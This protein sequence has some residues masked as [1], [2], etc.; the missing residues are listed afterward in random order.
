MSFAPT[1]EQAAI[2]AAAQTGQNLVIQAGAG[3][4]KTSTL[5][6]IAETLSDKR[7]LYIAFNKAI[8]NEA[9]GSMGSNVKASTAHS[10]AFQSVGKH[11]A[12]RLNAKRMWPREVARLLGARPITIK[13]ASDEVRMFSD[14][15]VARMAMEMVAQFCRTADGQ[16]TGFHFPLTEGIDGATVSG[17]PIRGDNHAILAKHVLPYAQTMWADLQR[18]QGQFPFSHDH[19]LKMYQLSNPVVSA[20]VLFLDEAQDAN[21]VIAAIVEAQSHLQI[22]LV[23]DSAQAIYGFTGAVDAMAKFEARGTTSMVLSQSFRFGPAVANVANVFLDALDAPLRISGFEPRNSVL[24]TLDTE[25]GDKADAVLC[26]TNAGC[27]SELIAAQAQG[28]KAAIVGGVKETLSFIEAA[29]RL[30]VGQATEHAVLC[31]FLSWADVEKFVAEEET[32]GDLATMVKMIQKHGAP[33]LQQVLGNAADERNADVVISTAHK[34]KGREWN[35]VRIADFDLDSDKIA[36]ADLMLAY[37]AVT[38][39]M[40]T[41]DVGTLSTYIEGRPGAFVVPVEETVEEA[42]EIEVVAPVVEP[43]VVGTGST[44][45]VYVAVDANGKASGPEFTF[46]DA[47]RTFAS[48]KGLAV[49]SVEITRSAVTIL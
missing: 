20:D 14:R 1:P 31:A 30:M 12:G 22:I 25:H 10:L 16:I 3:T 2:V 7:C 39:A 35:A 13:T 47:A 9:A 38:R 41:L 48:E 4:G 37:V 46:E 19:Y 29:Q 23:G 5:R 32:T 24:A 33:R 26:R 45:T 11:Y 43:V 17:R 15:N 34:S 44:R 6:L 8:A 36:D 18:E 27:L 28:R 42:V 21:P 49:G 40:K